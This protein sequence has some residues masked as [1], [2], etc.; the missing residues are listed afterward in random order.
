VRPCLKKAKNRKQ[1]NNNNNNNKNNNNT[2]YI[3]GVRF[4]ALAPTLS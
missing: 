3:C 2:Q 1:T 4:L